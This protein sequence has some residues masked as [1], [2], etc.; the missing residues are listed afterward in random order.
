MLWSSSKEG[1]IV[2]YLFEQAKKDHMDKGAKTPLLPPKFSHN[3][4]VSIPD[5]TVRI[6]K[7]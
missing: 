2:F 7:V 4:R 3:Q 5:L 6:S 1:V